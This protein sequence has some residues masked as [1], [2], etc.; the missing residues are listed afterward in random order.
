MLFRRCVLEYR[1]FDGEGN[2]VR[3]Y[4]VHPVIEGTPEFQSALRDL[5]NSE[6]SAVSGQ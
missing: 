3:W 2:P 6:H 5:T 4:D 1:E